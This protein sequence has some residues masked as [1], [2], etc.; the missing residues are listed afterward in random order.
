MR[1]HGTRQGKCDT[2]GPAE[3]TEK[4]TRERGVDR[5]AYYQMQGARNG[6]LWATP[7]LPPAFVSSY[8]NTATL[9]RLHIAYRSLCYNGRA[10]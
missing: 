4:W 3:T 2:Q 10:E 5:Q 8:W 1:A 9:F 6:G 7:G